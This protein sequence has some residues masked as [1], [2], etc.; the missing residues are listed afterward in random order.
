MGQDVRPAYPAFPKE[1]LPERHPCRGAAENHCGQRW[2]D[3]D[4]GAAHRAEC[5]A[6]AILA[7]RPDLPDVASGKWAVRA[8]HRPVDGLP[9]SVGRQ[10]L[11]VPGTADGS[12]PAEESWAGAAVERYI[13]DAGRSAV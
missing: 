12:V 11:P 1:A 3:E 13:P 7:H 10:F 2:S 5:T 8:Q 4:H 6:D 9:A